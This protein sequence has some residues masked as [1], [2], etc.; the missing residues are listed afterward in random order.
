[1][2]SPSISLVIAPHWNLITSTP[3]FYHL[4]SKDHHLT[5]QVIY[6]YKRNFAWD[7]TS[8]SNSKKQNSV[9]CILQTFRP[10]SGTKPLIKPAFF[11]FVNIDP[12][13]ATRNSILPHLIK[14]VSLLSFQIMY[15]SCYSKINSK[16]N[17]F[18][19]NLFHY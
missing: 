12:S 19:C 7:N 10:N 11:A 5:L 8:L 4:S 9:I 18:C 16:N 2:V 15:H 17:I 1:M 6:Q 14:L 13:L 3:L